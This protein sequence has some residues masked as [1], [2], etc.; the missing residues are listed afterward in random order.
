[1]KDLEKK[2]AIM[3]SEHQE[4]MDRVQDSHNLELARLPTEH[5]ELT[6][7]LSNNLRH[8]EVSTLR[9]PRLLGLRWRSSSSR[10]TR[11]MLCSSRRCPPVTRPESRLSRP[12]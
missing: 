6:A 9:P 4:E 7:K 11:F 1:M 3:D 5:R 2:L 12:S 10:G 8:L